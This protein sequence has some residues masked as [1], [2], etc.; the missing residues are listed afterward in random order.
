MRDL[1]R[2]GP[3]WRGLGC[4]C[5]LGR[6]EQRVDLFGFNAR[7]QVLVRPNS[8]AFRVELQRGRPG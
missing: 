3:G 4:C 1:G 8:A 2:C 7:H 6:V 5:G